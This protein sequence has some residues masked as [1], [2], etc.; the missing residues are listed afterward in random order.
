VV[1]TKPPSAP[2]GTTE[3][4]LAQD[5]AN[6]E[7]GPSPIYHETESSVI[8]SGDDLFLQTI[9]AGAAGDPS[10]RGSKVEIYWREG[11]TPTDH[12][13]E[14]IYLMGSTVLI[15]LPNTHYTRDETQ[16]TGNGTNT[17]L[18]IRRERLST[19]AQEIDTVVRGYTQ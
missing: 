2:P 16:M 18:V 9:A 13:V 5:D 7:V 1:A 17:K 6:L 11:S 3:F 4:V 12:L 19:A 8:G 15:T 10:E 14:R